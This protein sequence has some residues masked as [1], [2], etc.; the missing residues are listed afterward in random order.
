MRLKRWATLTPEQRAT[1]PPI[2]PDFVVELRSP[3]DSLRAVQDKMQE[4]RESGACLGWLIDPKGKQVEIYRQG[5]DK[6]ILQAPTSLSG[7][8]VLPGFVLDLHQIL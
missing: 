8:S 7:E 4:Y 5:Q 3:S 1:F 2:C 6:Q